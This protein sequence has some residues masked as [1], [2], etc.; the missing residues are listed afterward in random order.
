MTPRG[1]L[2]DVLEDRLVTLGAEWEEERARPPDSVPQTPIFD[3][4]APPPPTTSGTEPGAMK[5]K[6][7][8][9]AEDRLKDAIA[10]FAIANYNAAC[11]LEQVHR[12]SDALDY[13]RKAVEGARQTFGSD[14]HLTVTSLLLTAAA[15]TTTATAA[16]T[17]PSSG[18][19]AIETVRY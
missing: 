3:G 11:E 4:T 19:V 1:L 6:R 2:A 8:A 15:A 7:E 12:F 5:K 18:K 17:C 10:K 13:H 9:S 14:Y 16:L